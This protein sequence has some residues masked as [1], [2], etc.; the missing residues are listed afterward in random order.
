VSFADVIEH[1]LPRG[2]FLPTTPGTKFV[3][4]G[5]AIAADVH[6]KNHHVDG[7]F[8]NFVVDLRLLL[9]NGDVLDCSPAQNA[10]VFWATVGGMG[11]TGVIVSTRFRLHR[12]ESAWY[13]VTYHRTANLDDT[14]E[15]FADTDA[16]YRYSVAWIDCLA[17]GG[18]L[19][20]SVAMLANEARATDLPASLAGAAG[21]LSASAS[22]PEG[23][24]NRR[25]RSSCLVVPRKR[26]KSVPVNLPGWVL[27]PL[28]V[29]AF[30]ELYYATHRD[31]RQFVDFDSFFYP[32][33]GVHRW[34][35]I[36][37]K[38]GFVQYQALFP[39]DTSRAGL[40]ELLE[41]I[42]ASRK[43]SFLAVLKTTG[44]A[45]P[46]LLSFPKPG[47]TLA[48]DFPHTGDDLA[49]L[50]CE[51]D[52]IVLRHGGRLYLAKDALTTPH[53]FAAMYPRLPEFREIK[54][55]LD[56][57]NRFVSS[58]ARRLRIVES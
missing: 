44:A 26:G 1:F 24:F 51:C 23:R 15:C 37:G 17:R 56:P 19:G 54:H 27:N 5:G 14:L 42:T 6:G 2:W 50:L 20:R 40:V 31:G 28:S 21:G 8:G 57:Q 39:R 49:A 45:N 4:V 29:R 35:R 58:Q 33:D 13:D 41:R 30:N 48:L 52:E 3:T 43:G 22:N 53:A 11:L 18:S 46:G 16:A 36:Y 34:N 12:V 32:L 55:R 7:S 9:A 47:V 25:S 38:R 10:D